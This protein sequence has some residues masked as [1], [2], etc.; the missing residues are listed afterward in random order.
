MTEI[1]EQ[2]TK[3]RIAERKVLMLE[4]RMLRSVAGT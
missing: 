1:Q 2:R 3:E 4:I